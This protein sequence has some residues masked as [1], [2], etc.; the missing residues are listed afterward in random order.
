MTETT[1]ADTTHQEPITRAIRA[2]S[3]PNLQ[4]RLD[5]LNRRALKL[6]VAPVTLAA[7]EPYIV[8]RP[9]RLVEMVKVTVSAETPKLAGWTL[10]A[11]RDFSL[12]EPLLNRVP[13]G[14]EPDLTAFTNGLALCEHCQ[15]TRKRNET[16]VLLHD[17]GTLRQVGRD[18]LADFLG[19]ATPEH[20]IWL[21]DALLEIGAALDEGEEW[22]DVGPAIVEIVPFLE[23][24]SAVIRKDGWLGRTKAREFGKTATA[25]TAFGDFFPPQSGTKAHEEFEKNRAHVEPSDVERAAATL[26]WAREIDPNDAQDYRRNLGRACRAEIVREKH[27]GI[28]AS[29]VSAWARETEHEIER[30]RRATSEAASEFVGEVGKRLKWT[31]ATKRKPATEGLTLTLVSVKTWANDFGTTHFYKF[32]D[33]AGNVVAWFASSVCH[34]PEFPYQ[35]PNL[36]TERAVWSET[37]GGEE[38]KLDKTYRVNAGIKKHEE[39]RG[40]KQ[41][42]IARAEVVAVVEEEVE[43]A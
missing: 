3:L 17:D 2:A 29:A 34:E 30:R 36:P 21:A 20:L 41:T 7:G 1:K 12:E 27:S 14:P 6:G 13:G 28:V 37:F 32:Y 18:C 10:V 39:F 42:T 35:G 26:A 8:K 40:V 24:V 16:F 33:R 25:D 19:G 9:P 43:G 22:G 31:A 23:V 15:K 11:V 38:I 5:R 4:A